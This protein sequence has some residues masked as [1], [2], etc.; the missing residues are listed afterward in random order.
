M[1]TLEDVSNLLLPARCALCSRLPKPL[2]DSCWSRLVFSIRE[3]RKGDLTGVAICDYSGEFA[4]LLNEFKERGQVWLGKLLADQIP[5][6]VDKPDVAAV[7][8][9]PSSKMNFAKRGFVPAKVIAARMAKF[10]Q[11]PLLNFQVSGSRK[12]QSELDRLHRLDNLAGTM[13]L[14]RPLRG[15]RVLLVDD[16]VTTGATLSEMARAVAEAG[17]QVAGFITVAETLPKSLTKI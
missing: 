7:A 2:C 1:S 11:L 15:R 4:D 14:N 17:G 3:V 13:R 10:W 16:I 8:F 9:A 6:F 5:R 12:D